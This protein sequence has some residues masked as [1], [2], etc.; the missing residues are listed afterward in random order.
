[1]VFPDHIHNFSY[2][3]VHLR[4]YYCLSVTSFDDINQCLDVTYFRFLS[5]IVH[6]KVLKG[7]FS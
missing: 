7:L 6:I 5:V 3:T 1:M 4:G 2:Y